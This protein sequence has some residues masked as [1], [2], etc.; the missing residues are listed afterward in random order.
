MTDKPLQFARELGANHTVSSAKEKLA[1]NADGFIH[2]RM[3]E[4]VVEC[5][6][7]SQ[8]VRSGLDIA[9]NAQRITLTGWPERETSLP[10][11]SRYQ[12]RSGYQWGGDQ[13]QWV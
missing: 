3:A 2:R 12:E 10:T 1:E 11:A 8:E 7:A 5:S 6:G 9:S 4:L 13:R